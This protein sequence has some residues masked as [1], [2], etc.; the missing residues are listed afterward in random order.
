MMM[1][2]VLTLACI[3]ITVFMQPAFSKR[4]FAN[5]T[6]GNNTAVLVADEF[7]DL[8]YEWQAEKL[9][10]PASVMKIVMA[11]MVLDQWG[12]EHRFT[13]DFY[14]VNGVLWVK[15]Y[16]DPFLIS[17]ELDKVV[18]ELVDRLSITKLN[19]IAVDASYF[20]DAEVAS[21]T[22]VNDPY[23]APLS[24]VATNF[25][26]VYISKKDG[27]VMTAEPQ[28]PLTQTAISLTKKLKSGKHR[29][30]VGSA[31]V[32]QQYFAELLGTKLRLQ[33]I[34]IGSAVSLGKTVPSGAELVYRHLNS[35]PL[36]HLLRGTLEYSNN[37]I[38]NQLFMLLGTQ[39][40]AHPTMMSLAK[41]E[42]EKRLKGKYGE[43]Q[44]WQHFSIHEGAGLSRENRFS[45]KQLL[46]VL[47]DFE[48]NK[49]LLKSYKN[50]LVRAK[51]GTLNGVRTF[52]GYIDVVNQQG[53][54][55]Y[56]FVFLFNDPIPYRYR[57]TLL[58]ELIAFLGTN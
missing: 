14:L 5:K 57:E 41:S 23:N 9:L 6:F 1:K 26:T 29:V 44:H 2:Q 17:E 28:T 54:K 27:Q 10:I 36:N 42:A 4:N 48:S 24:A 51:T 47:R 8:V 39:N 45:A 25:N 34:E 16:G 3:T 15:G 43:L 35:N 37:F 55:P 22:S 18:L 38:A 13:T 31:R 56:Y 7:G 50:G 33:G 11:Q 40:L 52:A 19:G 12:A 46:D 58:D 20:S 32:G 49:A 53:V 21:R 30:N